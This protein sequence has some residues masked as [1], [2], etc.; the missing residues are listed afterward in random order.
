MLPNSFQFPIQRKFKKEKFREIWNF[1]YML[2]LVR[3][4]YSLTSPIK[5]KYDKR[6]LLRFTQNIL[7]SGIQIRDKSMQFAFFPQQ[8]H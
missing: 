7:G 4:I 6:L 2:F 8:D 3:I 5:P 1:F